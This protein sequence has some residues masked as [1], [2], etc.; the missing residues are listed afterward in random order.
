MLR[1]AVDAR[2]R[3]DKGLTPM[4][5]REYVWTHGLDGE[6]TGVVGHGFFD[7]WTDERLDQSEQLGFEIAADNPKAYLLAEDLELSHRG[8]S[9]YISELEESR[10]GPRTT[11][12]VEA[13]ALWY[14]L[15]EITVVGSLLL[16][17]V[18]PSAGL[19]QIL[20]PSGWTQGPATT[21]S[22]DQF[23]MEQE[24]KS[25]LALLRTWAK[26]TGR[27]LTFNTS[28]RSVDLVDERGADLGLAFRY[29][30]NVTN[31]RRRRRP[32]ALTVLY[33]F[34]ADDLT[35]AGINGGVPF[36]EDFSYYTARGLDL[37]TARE[38]YTR[39]KV[40]ADSSFIRDVDL[41]P[42]A[43]ARLAIESQGFRT[44][45][46]GVLDLSEMSGASEVAAV[47]DRVQ[48]FDPSFDEDVA[49]TVSRVRR[50]WLQPWRNRI[51]LSTLPDPIRDAAASTSRG[52]RSAEWIQFV[53][54]IGA[55]YQIRNDGDYTTNRIPLAFREGGRA[56]FHLDLNAVGVGAGIMHVEVVNAVDDAAQFR[57][58]DLDYTDGDPVRALL[59]WAT[60][61]LLGSYDFRV[62]VTT[63]ATGGPDPANGVDIAADADGESSWWIMAQGAVQETPAA[64]NSARFDYVSDAAQ[65]FTIPDGVTE[66]EYEIVAAGSHGGGL[67]CKLVFRRDVTPGTVYDVYAPAEGNARPDFSGLGGWPG[68]ADT[69]PG[70]FGDA[71]GGGGYAAVIPAGGTI[72]DAVAVTGAG[73]GVGSHGGGQGGDGGY[74]QGEAGGTEAED[75]GG[76][77]QTAGGAAGDGAAGDGAPGTQGAGGVGGGGTGSWETGGG[78]AGWFGGAGGGAGGAVFFRG[79]AG[80]GGSSR[81][82]GDAFDIEIVEGFNDGDGYVEFRWETPT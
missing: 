19:Q 68:G 74:L 38:L 11:V 60:E 70:I 51:E 20:R 55:L 66:L 35:I 8:R 31:V 7:L 50:H 80:G 3:R 21:T 52:S 56:N 1:A 33:P 2:N 42:A 29:G 49:A 22:T 48:V 16:T 64:A 72:T 10:Q 71:G 41:L 62:R 18:T 13:D 39:S 5:R 43:E 44:Y 47:A 37:T 40:W 77:T 75:G 53:G 67:G 78:G 17:S 58:L 46:L 81:L 30:R 23:S 26:I 69:G 14:R 57:T 82:P 25:V 36:V 27:T 79:G 9:F 76:G 45:E 4:R 54:P 24:D 6:Q 73:G 32:P 63:T 61:D 34:G 15:G 59:S 12:K 28:T 65:S